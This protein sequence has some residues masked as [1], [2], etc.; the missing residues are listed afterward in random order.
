MQEDEVYMRKNEGV[1]KEQMLELEAVEAELVV[2]G[3]WNRYTRAKAGEARNIKFRLVTGP[4]VRPHKHL[5]ATSGP[6]T[7]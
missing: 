2:G 5:N 3:A 1:Q 6:H 4:G 7:T